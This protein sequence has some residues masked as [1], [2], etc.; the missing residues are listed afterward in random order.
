[1]ELIIIGSGTC[2]I[3]ADRGP[4]G[5]VLKL[6]DQVCLLDGGT[7]TLIK[8]MQVGVNYREI[9]NVF[10]THLHPDHTMDLIPLL[11]ATKHTP[12]FNRKKPLNLF[13]PVGFK[14]FYD[15]LV[16]LYGKGMVEVAYDLNLR[17]LQQ[18]KIEYG[19]WTVETRFV[20]H[21]P[22]AIGYRF[23]QDGRAF[24]YSGDTDYGEGIVHLARNAHV[25]LLECSFP[26]AM[27]VKGHLSPSVAGQIAA[28]ANVKKLI[29]THFY[30]PCDE[31]DIVET[32]RE[33]FDGPIVKAE[34][35]RRMDI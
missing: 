18:N 7:G 17:E 4:S 28:E 5:Y 33:H 31:I 24:A 27:K 14:A 10:Y 34:D 26:D 9:D 30:P 8:C 16:G 19:S 21:T 22:N 6:R 25:L 32:V 12:G 13:G 35:L 11:F 2:V 3:R 15:T 29:L 23:E 1:M 20:E